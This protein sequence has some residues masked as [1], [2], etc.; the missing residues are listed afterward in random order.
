MKI[1][2]RI[3]AVTAL[4]ALSC[5][6]FLSSC[7]KTFLDKNPL[8]QPS[9]QTFWKSENDVNLALVGVY[10]RLRGGGW[11]G[12]PTNYQGGYLDGLTDIAYVYWG[13]FGISDMS[14]GTINANSE[15]PADMFRNCYAGIA[16]CNYFLGNVDKVKSMDPNK[17]NE[18]KG[19]VRFIRALFYFNLVEYFADVPL[20]KESPAD[21][22]AAKIAQSPKDDVLAFVMEDLDFAISV[23]P[24]KPY[25]D[26][27][28]VKGS[29][30]GIKTRVLLYEEKW[31]DAS[32]LAQQIM[33]S[34]NFS[35][36]PDYAKMFKKEGQTNNPEIMFSC[37]YQSPDGVGNY[38]Y[39]IEY[40]AHIFL[41]QHFQDDF[42]CSDGKSI[43][44]SP[45]YNPSNPYAN[46]DPRF[47]DIVRLP[48]ED[49]PGFYTYN[50]FNPTGV[51]NRKYA[52]TTIPGNYSNVYLN[53]WNFIILRYA[54]VLL[55][56]AEAQNES[57]G[58]D[59][60]VYSAINAVRARVNM[61]PVDE[62][63]YNT[64]ASVRNYIRHEREIEFALEGL[65]FN[66]LKRWHIADSLLPTIIDADGEH[67]V[68]D[69]RQYLWP[70]PQSELDINPQLKQNEGY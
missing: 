60:S 69:K 3:K 53:D 30:M 39:N 55:M 57:S 24:D 29:A 43:S 58:P 70:F 44:E 7:K 47:Y 14:R 12:F 17:L 62:S 9:S 63:K 65:R 45:L 40:I 5:L 34:G 31:G 16:S 50:T 67:L 42:E 46:R 2:T 18:Y 36:Y 13:L 59:A 52:D 19:E 21:P 68:F 25:T 54:D 49:W 4:L 64:Q 37:N 26:G 6:F 8:D 61:P 15:L 38:G 10:N 22:Q 23:L 27:H 51:L 11:G 35:L 66:D 56:Y 1:I 32:T 20:Y 41:R 48:G 28:A 33:S